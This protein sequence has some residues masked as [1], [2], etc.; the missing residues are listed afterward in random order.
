M[1]KKDWSTSSNIKNY[2]TF[3]NEHNWEDICIQLIHNIMKGLHD[4]P[5]KGIKIVLG[6]NKKVN[7]ELARKLRKEETWRNPRELTPRCANSYL[8]HLKKIG[9]H[10]MK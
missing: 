2:F 6:T 7:L 8:D 5:L 3:T 9:H 4:N 10:P 1:L